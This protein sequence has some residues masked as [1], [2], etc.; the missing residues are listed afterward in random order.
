MKSPKWK[1]REEAFSEAADLLASAH[2]GP[3]DGDRLRLGII[4]LLVHENNGGLKEPDDVTA[5]N[6]GEGYGEDKS[7]YYVGLVGY[8]GQMDDERA[9]PALLGA[10]STGGIAIR[11][12]ARFGKKALDPTLAGVTGQDAHLAED[13]LFV[14]RDMLEFGLVSDPDSRRRIKD[15]LRAALA[16][17]EE[18]VRE[19]AI[20][21]IEY[22]GDRAEFVPELRDVAQRD[23][24]RLDGHSDDGQDNGQI[25]P[26]RRTARLLLQQIANHEPPVVDRGLPP[27]EY[28]PVNP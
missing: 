12:V 20:S 1:Q 25:Y 14:I 6:Y 15:A 26:V 8:L 2:T 5:E 18:L 19:L 3:K 10:A 9:I 4:Q 23:P 28:Q 16:S 22:L 13:A 21:A 11:A 24:Y 17:H 27:S 7:E